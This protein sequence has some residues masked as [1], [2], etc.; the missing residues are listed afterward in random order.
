M[1]WKPCIVVRGNKK[2]LLLSATSSQNLHFQCPLEGAIAC[3]TQQALLWFSMLCV[4][5]KHFHLLAFQKF[6]QFCSFV[7]EEHALWFVMIP[8]YQ[9]LLHLSLLLLCPTIQHKGQLIL[10]CLQL[11][12]RMNAE[13]IYTKE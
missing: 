7:R 10:L 2:E 8:G 11:Y 12:C 4:C 5:F 9:N 6:D 1:Y 13:R 3:G